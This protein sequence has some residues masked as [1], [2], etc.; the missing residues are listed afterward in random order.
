MSFLDDP[1]IKVVRVPS[2][3]KPSD[4]FVLKSFSASCSGSKTQR[5]KGSLDIIRE[6]KTNCFSSKQRLPADRR[7]E[8]SVAGQ[9]GQGSFLLMD[10]I[11]AGNV[12][13]YMSTLRKSVCVF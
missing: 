8:S 10:D 3:A 5:W 6:A 1:P 9:S 7:A 13:L 2:P 12:N 4:P 11:H